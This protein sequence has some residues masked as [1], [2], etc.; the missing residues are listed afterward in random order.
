MI[1]AKLAA[2]TLIIGVA[3]QPAVEPPAIR[4]L[5]MQQRNAATQAYVRNATACVARAVAA[6]PRFRRDDPTAGL[7][8]LI[9]ETMPQCVAPMRAMIEAYDRY[10]G[11]GVGEQFFGGPYL[12]VLPGAVA[13]LAVE[14]TD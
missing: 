9:V 3:A 10:F 5:S 2:A 13:K 14:L 8:D 4:Q 12:D 11:E 1:L 7:G 6:H